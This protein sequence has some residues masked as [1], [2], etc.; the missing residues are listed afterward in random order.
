M[1]SYCNYTPREIHAFIQLRLELHSGLTRQRRSNIQYPASTPF[2]NYS[3]L[4]TS[5]YVL[6][7]IER[8][9]LIEPIQRTVHCQ[10]SS[11]IYSLG[12]V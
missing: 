12:V 9:M 10:T 6:R 1:A 4:K 7:D 2:V 5:A 11:R 3:Q 8:S